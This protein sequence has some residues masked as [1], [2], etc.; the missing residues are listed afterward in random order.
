MKTVGKI[1]SFQSLGTLDGPGV[2]YVIFMQG[3]PLRCACCH[4]PETWDTDKGTDYSVEDVFKNVLKYREYFGK[5]GGVTVSGGEPLLQQKFIID[6]FRLCKEENIS[7][8]LDTSGCIINNDTDELLELTDYCLLDFKYTNA[9]DYLKF[10]GL[11][12]DYPIK[13]LKKLDLHKVDTVLRQ[14]I[15]RGINDST[16]DIEKL[17]NIKD[18]YTCVSEIELLPFRKLCTEKYENL[19]IDFRFKDMDETDE[20]T[21]NRLNRCI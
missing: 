21:I 5:N 12:I 9:D 14:V 2:R 11:S 20:E 4:N 15:I 13:F 6:L 8:C 19:N 17:K 16:Q 1:N 18:R 10:T 7:T 3:C